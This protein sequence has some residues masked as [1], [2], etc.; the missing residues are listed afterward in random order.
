MRA[1]GT[2]TVS[3]FAPADLAPARAVATGTPAGV[4]TMQKRFEGEIT[5]HSA[6]LFTYALDHATNVGGYVAME[7]FEGALHGRTGTF[8]F[9]HSATTSGDD[10]KDESFV[11]IP[12]SGTGQLTGITGTGG[13]TDE[14]DGSHS[15]W[16]DYDLPA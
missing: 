7:S 1:T 10:R 14:S 12:S 8:N 4:A 3:G 9:T 2:F 11:I 5:G 16:F 15:I 13:L 6:T